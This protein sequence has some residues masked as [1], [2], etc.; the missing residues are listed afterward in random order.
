MNNPL[1]KSE[2][3]YNVTKVVED[4]EFIDN[5]TREISNVS[6]N[7]FRLLWS[8][9]CLL[10]SRTNVKKTV[11]ICLMQ[12]G[13]FSSTHGLYVFFPEIVDKITT[14]SHHYPS[15]HVTIC[16]ALAIDGDERMSNV[17]KYAVALKKIHACSE[18]VEEST[19]G[20][21]L[22]MEV[23][24]MVGFLALT[25][26]IDR[27]SKLVLL[28]V[29]LFGCAICGFITQVVTVPIVSIYFYVLFMLTFLAANVINATTV[30][31]FP[32]NLR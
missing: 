29:I 4:L 16:E 26:A 24:Y 21:S 23:L 20:H 25:I 14:Y 31:L 1:S 6:E 12:C 19:F 27:V 8:Q 2:L 15:G 9:T 18:Q 22:A 11:I 28:N 30:D 13:V 7:P 3:D 32:T 10:F 17:T 5:D